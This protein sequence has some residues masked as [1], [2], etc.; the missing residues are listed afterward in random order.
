MWFKLLSRQKCAS[1]FIKQGGLIMGE[2]IKS[3][4][5]EL[6]L[7]QREFADRCGVSSAMICWIERGTKSP[8]LQLGYIIAEVLEV[9]VSWLLG[10]DESAV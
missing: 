9:T 6:G 3:R 7:S 2:R 4:R 10:I 1:A 8:S 5:E